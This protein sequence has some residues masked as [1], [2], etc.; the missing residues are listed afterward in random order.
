MSDKRKSIHQAR[1]ASRLCG[2]GMEFKASF[3]QFTCTRLALYSSAKLSLPHSQGN[4]CASFLI[5]YIICND[6]RFPWEQFNYFK[7][8]KNF[9]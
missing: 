5:S 7:T 4:L 2:F 9:A 1:I 6:E 3:E 8:N